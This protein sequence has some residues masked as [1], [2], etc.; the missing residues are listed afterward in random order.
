MIFRSKCSVV[1]V[2]NAVGWE[3]A[4]EEGFLGDVALSS[5]R[6]VE[7]DVS[8]PNGMAGERPIL[9]R[10]PPSLDVSAGPSTREPHGRL[11]PWGVFV[12]SIG[13]CD[14]TEAREDEILTMLRSAD[15]G[16]DLIV[17]ESL[18]GRRESG[19]LKSLSKSRSA[20]FRS[21]NRM[22]ARATHLGFEMDARWLAHED[23]GSVISRSRYTVLLTQGRAPRWPSIVQNRGWYWNLGGYGSPPK[24]DPKWFE[25]RQPSQ[26]QL[27]LLSREWWRDQ[28]G[29]RL[30]VELARKIERHFMLHPS[31]TGSPD[32]WKI[33]PLRWA[34]E[35]SYPISNRT[36][37]CIKG[38]FYGILRSAAQ[39][40]CGFRA[41]DPRFS[42]LPDASA[43]DLLSEATDPSAAMSILWA[44][45]QEKYDV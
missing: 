12:A 9:A 23:H 36:I 31:Y 17:L 2:G 8:I 35:P 13:E 11:E 7:G 19:D 24:P 18:D 33:A 21:I 42:H 14:A 30:P 27:E 26:K 15:N 44:N 6:A 40:L 29:G 38:E 45:Y 37:V 5:R 34:E 43:I 25:P 20:S 32:G 4:V 16:I 41:D 28:L 22:A 39:R 3:R 1:T 10:L